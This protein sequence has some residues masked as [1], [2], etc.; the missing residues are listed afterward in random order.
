MPVRFA[1]IIRAEQ[2][3][4]SYILTLAAD[5]F[6]ANLTDAALRGV[7]TAADRARLPSA[8]KAANELYAINAEFDPQKH[9]RRSFDAFEAAA[10]ALSRH[11]PFATEQ[12]AFFTVRQI[13]KVGGLNWFGTW[14]S[15]N[16]VDQGAFSLRT[17][18]RYECEVYCL[19]LFDH[20]LDA[21]GK[22]SPLN[23][24]ALVADPT[25]SLGRADRG[26]GRSVVPRRRTQA[27]P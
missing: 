19:R 21:Q 4:T 26:G 16:R 17:G 7:M 10:T 2:V 13:S 15:P 22:K 8:A 3:G 18:K 1:R 23:E 6:A 24:L 11:A 14:A 12:T 9:K 5:A 20:P 27:L 25:G